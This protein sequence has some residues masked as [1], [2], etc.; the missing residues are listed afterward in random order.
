MVHYISGQ[1]DV[2]FI[3]GSRDVAYHG[4]CNIISYHIVR[5]I[6]Y[7]IIRNHRY[8]M[9]CALAFG[10]AI[11]EYLIWEGRPPPQPQ[12]HQQQQ[13]C[14]PIAAGYRAQASSTVTADNNKTPYGAER[15]R[16]T[17]EQAHTSHKTT[18]HIDPE[19]TDTCSDR[20]PPIKY[21]SVCP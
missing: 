9:T 2:C 13:D 17:Y 3:P 7:H 16:S 18:P 15:H 5:I 12:R 21:R 20:K 4:A 6:S 14:Q 1:S 19:Q 10:G 11:S 8:P